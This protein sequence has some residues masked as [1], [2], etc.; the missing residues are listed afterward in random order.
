MR[1]RSVLATSVLAS[2]AAGSLA[3]SAAPADA[4]PA[5]VANAAATDKPVETTRGKLSYYGRGFAGQ[6]TASGE[7]FDPEALTMAHRSLPFDTRVRVTNR[8]NGRSVVVRVNDRGPAV[9][10]RIGDVSLAAAR[11]LGML[12]RGVIEARLEVLAPDASPAER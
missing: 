2:M 6:A 12:E 3:Q 4:P 1:L 5:S 9:A 7:S 11:R 10:G 8:K